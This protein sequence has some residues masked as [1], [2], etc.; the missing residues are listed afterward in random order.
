MP[1]TI[2]AEDCNAV[3]FAPVDFPMMQSHAIRFFG[4]CLWLGLLPAGWAA[5]AGIADHG[6]ARALVISG[7]RGPVLSMDRDEARNLLFTAGADGTVRIWDPDTR[8]LV[9]SITVTSLR[10]SMLAVSPT[11]TRFAVLSTDTFHTFVIEEWDWQKAQRL[12]KI[13]LPDQPLFL[14]YS[15]S[16]R[17]LLCGLPRWESLRIMNASDGSPVP[18]HPEGFGIVGFATLSRSEKILMTYR[19]TGEISYWDLASGKSLENLPSVPLLSH[20]RLTPDLGSIVG[21]TDND[22]CVI[23]VASGTVQA[24]AGLPGIASLD[25]SPSGD[26]I[27]CVSQGGALSRWSFAG[28]SLTRLPDPP[29]TSLRPSLVRFTSQSLAVGYSSGDLASLSGDA[30]ALSFPGDARAEVTGMAVRGDA[31][32][33]ATASWIKVFTAGLP[34]AL[35]GGMNDTEA[36]QSLQLDN[37]FQAPVGL[38]F[39]DDTS[40]LVWQN[41]QGPGACSILD[42]RSRSFRSLEQPLPGPVIEA[43][44]DGN[45]CLLLA[46]DGTLRIMDLPAGTTRVEVRRPGAMWA[47][48]APENTVVVG[49]EA[50]DEQPGSL[51]KINIATGETDPIRTRN[52][53]TYE[54]RYDP[55]T[56]ALYSLGVA[57]DGTTNLV[58]HSGRDFQDDSVVDS[59]PGE[60]LSAS[61]SLD[62][63]TGALYTSLGRERISQWKHGS[64]AK[65][66]VSA[67]GTVGLSF[68]SGLLYSLNADS[69]VTIIDP[70]HSQRPAEL[71]V[72]TDGEWALVLPDGKFAASAGAETRV[73]VF[74]D[75]RPVQDIGAYLVPVRVAESRSESR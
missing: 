24:S 32:A 46:S 27:A 52:R 71:S 42:I 1:A 16:G 29:S 20:L 69:S 62:S 38:T 35:R 59:T 58:T 15:A 61:L 2:P 6:S 8:S 31:V 39:V 49:G 9:R 26:Q 33:L 55:V 4:L 21:S 73:G 67:L 50:G 3:P 7:H 34:G 47:T 37:P 30:S 19:L 25:I 74:S 70:E 17:Y 45:Q 56:N 18:F 66:P 65:L 28:G 11:E 72:F 5:A 41:A 14:R 22:L 36:V 13:P 63:A 51:V 57:A 68:G 10:A 75:E 48:F 23:D 53:Y 44:A 54:V 40:L 12:F 64:L 60:H 43:A